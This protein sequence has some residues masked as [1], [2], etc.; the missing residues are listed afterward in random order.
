M[1]NFV[2]PGDSLTLIAP[3][4]GVVSGGAYQIGQILVIAS[5][6]AAV[7]VEFAGKTT[8]VFNVTKVGSQAWTVGQI[9]YFDKENSRFTST[10]TGSLL[11]GVAMAAVG[12]GAG[13]TTGR[14]RLNGT[15]KPDEA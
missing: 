12:A 6:T 14:V 10:A 11:A 13:E 15:F 9:V 5:V 2:Q 1:E 3:S 8:G 7:G 4:G